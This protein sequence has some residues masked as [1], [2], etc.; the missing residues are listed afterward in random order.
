MLAEE[1][2]PKTAFTTIYGLYQWKRLPMGLHSAV[3]EWQA[4]M[5]QIFSEYLHD[6][7][8]IYIDDGIIH[9]N[10]FKDHLKHIT[11]ILSKGL[12]RWIN[13]ISIKMQVRIFRVTYLRLSG[14][15]KWD[16]DKS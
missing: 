8:E 10:C 13:T 11:L 16:N 2:R 6:I 14:R 3:A 9:S 7:M 1:D 15:C 5:D 12:F 4:S